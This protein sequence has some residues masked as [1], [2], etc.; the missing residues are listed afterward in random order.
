MF[1]TLIC[2]NCKGLSMLCSLTTRCNEPP[3]V[4]VEPGT[5]LRPSAP[6]LHPIFSWSHCQRNVHGL[7]KGKSSVLIQ[8]IGVMVNDRSLVSTLV[9]LPVTVMNGFI[10]M[11]ASPSKGISFQCILSENSK[12]F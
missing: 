5:T 3:K 7:G 9:T 8:C 6:H 4:I 2:A 10:C 12:G 1:E 11:S